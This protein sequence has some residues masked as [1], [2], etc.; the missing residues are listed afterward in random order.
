VLTFQSW[1]SFSI[2]PTKSCVGSPD[3]AVHCG[4]GS[5][6]LWSGQMGEDGG[7][8]CGYAAHLGG[9]IPDM[10]IYSNWSGFTG[11]LGRE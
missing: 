5:G 2:S 4:F 7:G 1:T 8:L 9:Y 10:E 3:G 6:E 11:A